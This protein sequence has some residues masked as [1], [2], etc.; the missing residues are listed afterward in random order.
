MPNGNNTTA[1]KIA[2]NFHQVDSQTTEIHVYDT[3]ADKQSVNWWTGEKGTEVTPTLFK[4]E[5]DEVA[6]PNICVRI[7]SRGGDVFAAEA[8]RTAIR[9]KRQDG[10]NVTCKIDGFCGSAA[11]G[12]AAACEKTSIPSSAWFMIHDPVVFA[13]GYYGAVD[14]Q[15]CLNMIDKIKQGIINAYAEKTGKDKSELAE[16]MTAETWYT[17]DEAVENGFCDEV[18]FEDETAKA[19]KSPPPE[20]AALFDVSMYQNAPAALAALLNRHDPQNGGFTYTAPQRNENKKGVENSMAISTVTELKAA[21]PELAAQIAE[22]AT[23]T[24]RKRIQDI[25]NIALAGF[26]GVINKAKFEAPAT[27]AEVAMNIVAEQKKQGNAYLEGRADDVKNS[28]TSGVTASGTE[29]VTTET[30]P[31]DTAID[32]VLPAT[33]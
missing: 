17:G 4:E 8:I 25:E 5:I 27:A 29:G 13:Y 32:N 6:T 28:G 16:L 14:F 3:I 31:Y 1:I 12:I 22:E 30:N 23:N 10:K 11:V 15:K 20:N 33:K 18:M 9:E 21:Y 26:E 19:D 2:W 7:N 24:E